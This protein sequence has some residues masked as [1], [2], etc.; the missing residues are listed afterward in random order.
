[1]DMDRAWTAEQDGKA[2]CSGQSSPRAG[3]GAHSNGGVTFGDFASFGLRCF[4]AVQ[5]EFDKLDL[6]AACFST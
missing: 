1:M 3:T 6:C 4:G 2:L 5:N